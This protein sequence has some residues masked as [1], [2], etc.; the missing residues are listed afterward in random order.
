[1]EIARHLGR[2]EGLMDSKRPRG[3]VRE[4][5]QRFVEC[6]QVGIEP[7]VAGSPANRSLCRWTVEHG[8]IVGGHLFRGE[9][10]KLLADISG[11]VLAHDALT[12]LDG[13]DRTKHPL[14]FCVGLAKVKG[15]H[16][17]E[18]S[19]IHNKC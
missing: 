5:Q 9:F 1:M 11:A 17:W 15:W 14:V 6:G 16:T 8:K 3:L 18:S 4:C 12:L 19:A 7:V 2:L 13:E 10:R